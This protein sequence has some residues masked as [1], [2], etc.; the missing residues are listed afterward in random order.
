LGSTPRLHAA[1]STSLSLAVTVPAQAPPNSSKLQPRPA[2]PRPTGRRRTVDRQRST[3]VPMARITSEIDRFVRTRGQD[4]PN[5]TARQSR[6]FPEPARLGQHIRSPATACRLRV[7][8]PSPPPS[9][10]SRR[11][12]SRRTPPHIL[13]R[14]RL[15]SAP[16]GWARHP[17]GRRLAEEEIRRMRCGATS[18]GAPGMVDA[19]RVARVIDQGS[20]AHQGSRSPGRRECV[21]RV[22]RYRS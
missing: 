22:P 7:A 3:S 19:L 6:T 15:R 18:Q 12:R 4:S 17:P 20:C 1:R 5:E 14:R 9:S 13:D 2:T 21:T 8:R 10:L 11:S 16:N